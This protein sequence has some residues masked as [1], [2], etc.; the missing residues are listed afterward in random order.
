M[1]TRSLVQ[2]RRGE[3]KNRFSTKRSFHHHQ[4]RCDGSSGPLPRHARCVAM[5]RIVASRPS[6]PPRRLVRLLL[7]SLRRA[8][9]MTDARQHDAALLSQALTTTTTLLVP[10]AGTMALIPCY[11][12]P[13]LMAVSCV[14]TVWIKCCDFWTKRMRGDVVCE[15]A[16]AWL[17]SE[18]WPV[19]VWLCNATNATL[20]SVAPA[21]Q[22]RR[23]SPPP[24]G[25]CSRRRSR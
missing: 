15:K 5:P 6:R 20:A 21:A 11:C 9:P 2:R 23:A 17:Q 10:S 12:C 24:L 13:I 22:P 18:N 16:N 19:C 1:C 7:S 14:A 4:K 3:F 8:A 25:V